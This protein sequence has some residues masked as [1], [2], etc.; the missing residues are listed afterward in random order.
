MY[1]QVLH[2]P[3]LMRWP[4]RIP[5]GLKVQALTSNVDLFPTLLALMG[6]DDPEQDLP[7]RDLQA[8]FQGP[9][10]EVHEAVF[11]ESVNQIMRAVYYQ[12]YK[13][14]KLY[15]PDWSMSED[16]L[17][18]AFQDYGEDVELKEREPAM[19][20]QLNSLLEQ[21][22]VRAE[23]KALPSSGAREVDVKTQEALRA[24]GYV[25]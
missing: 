17:Y 22:L 11:C 2:I 8:T 23:R 24:L 18:R 6:L 16:H 15:S 13:Y 19:V 7:G 21:W 5:A 4:G 3:C 1:N 12:D 20:A 9:H 14:I 10:T 25:D